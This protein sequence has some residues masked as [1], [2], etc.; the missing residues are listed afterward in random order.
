M[1][2]QHLRKVEKEL[3]GKKGKV[4]RWKRLMHNRGGWRGEQVTIVHGGPYAAVLW[5]T[6]SSK[7]KFDAA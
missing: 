4:T 6:R 3:G 7:S 1:S 2:E 5:T